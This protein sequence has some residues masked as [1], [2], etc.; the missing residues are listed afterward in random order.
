MWADA[1]R[2][3]FVADG[4]VPWSSRTFRQLPQDARIFVYIPKIGYVGVGTVI[5]SP[6]PFKDAE[7]DIDGKPM[8]LKDLQPTGTYV[9]NDDSKGEDYQEWIVPVS[10][11]KLGDY[12]HVNALLRRWLPT[13]FRND[14]TSR[15]ALCQSQ[16]YPR[17]FVPPCSSQ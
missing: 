15:Q 1:Q 3:G 8:P 13:G 4:G 2:Y 12:G 6:M 14:E 9:H 7:L 16:E 17:T 11:R 10:N 5:R